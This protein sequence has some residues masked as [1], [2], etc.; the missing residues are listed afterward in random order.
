MDDDVIEGKPPKWTEFRLPKDD[1][2]GLMTARMFDT[3]E[4]KTK[5]LH[6]GGNGRESMGTKPHREA[7]EENEEAEEVQEEAE[8]ESEKLQQKEVQDD[9]DREHLDTGDVD[10]D[11]EKVIQGT[12]KLHVSRAVVQPVDS[13]TRQRGNHGI[14]GT[15]SS[16]PMTRGRMIQKE[17]E[18]TS[19]LTRRITRGLGSNTKDGKSSGGESSGGDKSESSQSNTTEDED[20]S[21]SGDTRPAPSTA[22]SRRGSGRGWR[23]SGRQ[24]LIVRRSNRNK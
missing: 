9:G 18:R 14:R 17:R 10:E 19:Y 4:N 23:R 16:T 3:E 21:S 15:P 20:D 13:I 8:A 24:G 7:M 6:R 2:E 5:N 22:T 12:R 1:Y 11:E